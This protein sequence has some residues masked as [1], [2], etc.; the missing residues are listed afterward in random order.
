MVGRFTLQDDQAPGTAVLEIEATT[1]DG[2][3]LHDQ[4]EVTVTPDGFPLFGIEHPPVVKSGTPVEFNVTVDSE[5]AS[6][7][8]FEFSSRAPELEENLSPTSH[9]IP[10][11]DS[12][13]ADAAYRFITADENR[14]GTATVPI[15][16][17]RHSDG[18][19]VV[20]ETTVDVVPEGGA[21]GFNLSVEDNLPTIYGGT[22][23]ANVT[24]SNPNPITASQNITL[25]VNGDKVDKQSVELD[26][27]E[28][29]AIELIWDIPIEDTQQ[30]VITIASGGN[31][32]EYEIEQR[33][34]F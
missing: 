17:T 30:Y 31:K 28:T 4:K 18:A 2:Q 5:N 3:E 21:Y 1:T 25:A 16:I 19:S 8:E 32:E 27:N 6:S 20:T 24:L 29:T 14:T 7:E 12:E 10:I 34:E 26:Q 23:R 11:T 33:G 22:Y 9:Q 15:E 13:R